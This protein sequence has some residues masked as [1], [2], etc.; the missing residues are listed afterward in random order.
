MNRRLVLGIALIA[1]APCLGWTQTLSGESLPPPAEEFLLDLVRDAGLS[2]VRVTS[3]ER[4]ARRQADLMY[5]LLESVGVGAVRDQYDSIGDSVVDFYEAN[6]PQMEREELVAGMAD[7][8]SAGVEAAPDRQQMMHVLPTTNYTFDVAPS[9]VGNTEAFVDAILR[10]AGSDLA[11]YILPG[12]AER[13]FHLEVPRTLRTV[14]G[15]YA[16]ACG[17]AGTVSV[18]LDRDAG[19]YAGRYLT[20]GEA[21]PLEGVAVDRVTKEVRF[22]SEG[23]ALPLSG[24]L[25]NGHDGLALHLRA[26]ISCL[27]ERTAD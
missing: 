13:A 27:L 9:S 16:G 12:P 19:G 25:L 3:F 7:V 14:S 2:G 20:D 4:T 1:A 26:G 8:V 15:T 5:E 22:P 10:H 18:T 6:R 23:D 24:T 21:L 11:N 17:P